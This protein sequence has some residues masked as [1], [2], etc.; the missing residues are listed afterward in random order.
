MLYI[1]F[2]LSPEGE[3]P[4]CRHIFF[5]YTLNL[6]DSLSEVIL[7]H[8]G[9]SFCMPLLSSPTL[10]LPMTSYCF[11][12]PAP[13]PGFGFHCGSSTG[14]NACTKVYL[15]LIFLEIERPPS[16]GQI[17]PHPP[18]V[19]LFISISLSLHLS[20]S[21]WKA[22]P[23]P[24]SKDKFKTFPELIVSMKLLQMTFN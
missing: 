20:L 18:T 13:M 16:V 6:G 11:S 17:L 3:T 24:A 4:C 5:I 7:M 21:Q 12:G 10:E 9:I 15:S 23:L 22:T 14:F 8:I 19:S 2:I 1:S